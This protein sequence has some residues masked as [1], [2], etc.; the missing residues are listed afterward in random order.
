MKIAVLWHPKFLE[1]RPIIF[2]QFISYWKRQGW[3]VVCEKNLTIFIYQDH[4]C[5]DLKLRPRKKDT[6]LL[7]R[8]HYETISH[9]FFFFFFHTE[10][11]LTSHWIGNHNE[12]I[13]FAVQE[14]QNHTEPFFFSCFPSSSGPYQCGM[15]Y[16]AAQL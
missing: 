6:G 12:M 4:I 11:K 13:S 8:T 7:Q 14:H 2:I 5:D 3:L 15:G 10:T 1:I 16:Q 9:W